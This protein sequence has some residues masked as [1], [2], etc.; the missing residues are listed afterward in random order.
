MKIQFD[1]NLENLKRRVIEMAV[2]AQKMIELANQR[3]LENNYGAR[4]EVFELENQVNHLEIEI[5]QS[6]V[7]L[8]ALH[9]PAATD[10]RL[11]ISVIHM[12]NQI[13]RLGDLAVNIVKRVPDMASVAPQT[14]NEIHNIAAVSGQMVRNALEAFVQGDAEKATAVCAA[15]DHVDNLNR[16]LLKQFIKDMKDGRLEPETGVEMILISK[17][18]E[19][20][21]DTATNLAEEVVFY[22]K[23]KTIKHHVQE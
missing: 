21:G 9:Q 19:R 14:R 1:N 6:A 11:L 23:G 20:I 2:I 18:Y 7:T 8:I 15:D 22:L 10:L 12:I 4:D 3:L 13:E 5:E 16:A 17:H